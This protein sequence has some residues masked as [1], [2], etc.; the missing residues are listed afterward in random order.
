MTDTFT[1]DNCGKEF[2]AA[3]MKEVKKGGS[4][5]ALK[6]D[7]SC[8]DELMNEGGHVYGVEGDDKRRA[9]YIT[10]EPED[11]PDEPATGRRE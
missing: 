11:A 8:L 4:D 10:D 5:D 7:P 9:A 3:H 6:V 2:P 1:C